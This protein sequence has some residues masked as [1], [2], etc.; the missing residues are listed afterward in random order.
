MAGTASET[1]PG[2]VIAGAP[3]GRTLRVGV[4]GH[5]LDR[6]DAEAP[7]RLQ[8]QFDDLF[9]RIEQAAAPPGRGSL[10]LITGLADGAD[11]IAAECALARG[12]TIEAVLPF[13]RADYANDFAAGDP[14]ETFERLLGACATVMELPGRRDAAP[15]SSVAYERAG[16]ILLA[17]CDVL[18][19]VWD[20]G[21]VRGR[22]GAAQIVAEAVQQDLPVIHLD[23]APER[24]PLLLWDGLEDLALG[25][26]TVD[27]VARGSLEKLPMLLR[28]LTGAPDDAGEASLVAKFLHEPAPRR[29][30][31]LGYPL[32]LALMGVRRLR[33][34]DFSNDGSE[35]LAVGEMAPLCA[36]DDALGGR[37]QA[38]LL[39]RFGHANATAVRMAQLFRHGYVANFALAALAVVLSLLGL[40]L[41]SAFKP[42]LILAELA[43]IGSILLRTRRG[44]RA[45]WHRR[46]LDSRALA[47]RLRCLAVSARLGELNLRGSSPLAGGAHHQEWVQ[48][49]ARATARAIGLPAIT[50]DAA[51]L[52]SA[53][54]ALAGL[55]DGQIAYFDAEAHRMHLLEHRLHRLGTAL[56]ALTALSCVALLAFKLLGLMF[57]LDEA[58][59]HRVAIGAVI[60]GAA[61][62]ALGAAIYGIRMQGDF[63]G[64]AERAADLAAKLRIMRGSIGD[65][66]PDF[67]ALGRCAR[68]VTSLLTA[69]VA[70]WLHTTSARPLA[71]PG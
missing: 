65:G 5:R 40:V 12:W 11:C 60:V 13:A 46:W 16:R 19:A 14:L 61:L 45:D 43:I 37:L 62:P 28:Q 35:L 55:V 24:P 58:A 4:T 30:W 26:D 36:Q 69:D 34:S 56:F 51:Y 23:P 50:V 52:R 59:A 41:P 27:T 2:D 15:G 31:A 38:L 63:A 6:L 47:E 68:G 29:N 66:V 10:H 44:N 3:P 17:Q 67:D 42:V 1:A 18:V 57:A 21:P 7:R 32:L 53:R 8:E 22:G 54:A 20:G 33:R 39:P 64:S 70:S 25:I 48:W 9:A 71:L 49:Y